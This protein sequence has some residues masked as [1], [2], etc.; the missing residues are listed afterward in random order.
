VRLRGI[1]EVNGGPWMSMAEF[2]VLQLATNS[3]IHVNPQVLI[4]PSQGPASAPGTTV[5]YTV[6][7]TNNDSATCSATTFNLAAQVPNGWSSSLMDTSLTI[8]P[9]A[10]LA[11]TLQVASSVS[12][13]NGIYNVQVGATNAADST[14][15]GSASAGYAVSGA[16]GGPTLTVSASPNA[17]SIVNGN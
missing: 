8:N 3:C 13:Q 7:V 17:F 15:V 4:T 1:S 16:V 2:N 11:T 6:T 9:G 5:N 14:L 12:A 10:N